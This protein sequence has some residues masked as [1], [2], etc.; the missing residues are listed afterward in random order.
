MGKLKFR[1]NIYIATIYQ[2]LLAVI[3]LWLTR[4]VFIAVNAEMVHVSGIRQMMQVCGGGFVFD[5]VAATYFN[6][7]FIAMRILPFGFVYNPKYLKAT[8]IVYYI[9][10]SLMLIV[11]FS[12]TAYFRFTGT[13]LRWSALQEVMSDSNMLGILSGY[14]LQYW[15]VAVAIVIAMALV[16]WLFRRAEICNLGIR[17]RAVR[18]SLRITL[19]VLIGGLTVLCLRGRI[20]AGNPMS[21]ADATWYA[22]TPEQINAVLNSPFTVIRSIG[23]NA[24]VERLSFFNDEELSAIRS[25]VHIPTDS[26]QFIRKNVMFIILES[27]GSCFIDLFNKW[28][29]EDGKKM[30]GLMPFTDSIARQSLVFTNIM[31]TGKRSNEGITAILGTFPAFEPLVYMISPYNAQPFDSPATLLGKKGY[32]TAFFYGCNHGSFN[33]DQFAENSGF[34]N[35]YDRSKYPEPDKDYDHTWGIFD[36]QMGQ[37]VVKTLSTYRQP[38]A[39]AWFTISAHSPF[40]VPEGYDT[41]SFKYKSPTPQRGQEYTDRALRKFFEMAEKQ[42][43]FKNTV[44]V[45]TGDHGSREM[46]NTRYDKQFIQMHVPLIVYSPGFVK[47]AVVENIAGSQ[48]DIAPTVLSIMGYDEPYVSV[49]SNLLKEGA[50]NYSVSYVNGCYMIT[51]PE[52]VVMADS[53]CKKILNVYDASADPELTSPLKQPYPAE[54]ARMLRWTQAFL[55]DYTHRINDNALTFKTH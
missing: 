22:S 33:V 32:E 6:L 17:K 46:D 45:I 55:Q 28:G 7:V 40:K 30:S 49:G 31:A 15:W 44:F 16:V 3:V 29:E 18:I 25:S 42:P 27:G 43:W 36:E 19:F 21:I 23:K 35:M 26:T 10:N 5:V 12:D 8:N 34:M 47:P 20:G 2:W 38:W 37:F 50:E 13:R 41:S 54:T 52:Y 48:F 9:C 14:L 39:S 11:Q 1:T 24:K 53:Q 51:S 4:F